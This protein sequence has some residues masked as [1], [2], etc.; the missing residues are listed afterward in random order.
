MKSAVLVTTNLTSDH[1]VENI[2][3][4]LKRI[5]DEWNIK[6][7]LLEKCQ[8]TTTFPCQGHPNCKVIAA[9]D[10][11]WC[12]FPFSCQHLL[13]QMNRRF[14]SNSLLASAC[15][16]DPQFKKMAFSDAAALEEAYWHLV[17]VMGGSRSTTPDL[18]ETAGSSKDTTRPIT[19][20]RS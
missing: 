12:V 19:E 18:E 7:Q 20:N 14:E 11:F 13:T 5:T 16:L 10:C 8:L 1:T 17:N 3:K 9:T 6:N 2:A 15:L 4:E